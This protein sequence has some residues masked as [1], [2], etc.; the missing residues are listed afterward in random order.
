MVLAA[1]FVFGVPIKGSITAMFL[2]V[3]LAICASTGFGLLVSSFVK[4]QV[5]AILPPQLFQLYR[6]LT[7]QE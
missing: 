1:I 5:A 3:L 2:G 4:S 6:L 7:S